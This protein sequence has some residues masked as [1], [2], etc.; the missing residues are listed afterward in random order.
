MI[1]GSVQDCWHKF[2]RY[3]QVENASHPDGGR[4]IRH[5]RR[6][7]PSALQRKHDRRH[8]DPR[9]TYTGEYEPIAESRPRSTSY[10]PRPG[11]TFRS[12]STGPAVDSSPPSEPDLDWDFRLPRVKSI[13]TSGHKYGLAPLGV[14][15]VLWRDKAELPEEL[16]FQGELPRWQMPTFGINFSRPAGQIIAQYY[17]FVRFGH[18]GYQGSSRTLRTSPSSLPARSTS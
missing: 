7:G 3:C 12:M 15:W 17:M 14:G 6:G 5:R 1:T 13:S 8:G 2:A 16:I 9:V 10:S 11:S 4:A 18:D